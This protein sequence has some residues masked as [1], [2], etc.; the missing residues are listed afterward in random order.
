[1]EKNIPLHL[2]EILFGTSDLTESKQLSKLVK[3][4]AIR[5]IASKIYT[6]N[7][8]DTPEVIIKRNLFMILGKL[9]PKAVISHRSAFEF[10]PTQDG[11]IFLTYTYTK[12]ILFPGITV[13]LMEGKDGLDEDIPF[14]EGLYASQRERAY[15]ENMQISR[16]RGAESKTLPRKEIVAKLEQFI[17]VN[18]EDAINALRDKA[19]HLSVLLEMETEFD[20]LNHI[21]SA[22][23]CTRPSSIL[24]SS[25]AAVRAFGFPY[26]PNRIERFNTLYVSLLTSDFELFPD[27]NISEVS[28]RNF[29]F[30]ES[31]FS[32]YIEGTRFEIDEAKKIIETNEPMPARNDDSHDLLGTYYIV[33]NRKE[34][35]LTPES[36]E[37]LIK[38]LQYRHRV[39]L[40][41]RRSKM[42]GEFKDK[43]NFAG[44]TTFVDFN[45]VKGTLIKGFDYYNT[46]SSAFAKAAFMMFMISEIR[47]FLDGN[48]RIARVM[49]NAELS[50]AGVSKIIIPN[51]FR[52]DYLLALRKLTRQGD[53]EIFIKAMQ[54]V[55]KFSSMIYGDDF[56]TMREFLC[57]ANAF[58]ESNEAVLTF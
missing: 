36:P 11:H 12:N 14:I 22:L 30:F 18:G 44:D 55:H 38:I 8:S 46:L 7:F 39:M 25:L 52:D 37:E 3:Q 56:D 19:R 17:R 54:R 35:G 57:S 45:L 5:K 42:S 33:S 9:Y 21:I 34:M 10:E 29:A 58:S 32:N 49:M 15:L 2:Q 1:M 48:G 53:P 24:T 43:N 20:K 16:K 47:P 31:Y 6:P 40:A 27:R 4:G 41:S 50:K 13:H 23:L 51:V 26:D 28:Y